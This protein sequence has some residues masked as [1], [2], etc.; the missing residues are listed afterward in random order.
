MRIQHYLL[1]PSLLCWASLNSGYF[2]GLELDMIASSGVEYLVLAG[3]WIGGILASGAGFAFLQK[4]MDSR[5]SKQAQRQQAEKNR[6]DAAVAASTVALQSRQLET[7]A[8]AKLR[9]EW[10]KDVGTFRGEMNSLRAELTEL[11]RKYYLLQSENNGLRATVSILTIKLDQ[12]E[13][14]TG[15]AGIVATAEES[16]AVAVAQGVIIKSDR[17][18]A[19]NLDTSTPNVPTEPIR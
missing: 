17:E 18:I 2:G 7:D 5:A 10:R 12:F 6:T 4:I 11:Y 3:K 8:D 13:R 9:D 15:H 16:Q 1:S 14:V 19:A